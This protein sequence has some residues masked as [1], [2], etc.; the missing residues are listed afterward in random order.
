MERMATWG[1]ISFL[2]CLISLI[3]ITQLFAHPDGDLDVAVIRAF[4]N[5]QAS[6]DIAVPSAHQDQASADADNPTIDGNEYK[7]GEVLVKYTSTAVSAGEKFIFSQAVEA[8]KARGQVGMDYLIKR[9]TLNPNSPLARWRVVTLPKGV[10]VKEALDLFSSDP[11]VEV[12]EPN[13]I[14]QAK[15]IPNDALFE[16]LWGMK[17]IQAPLAWDTETGY[18]PIVVGVIDSGVD[19]THEDL[20]TNMWTNPGEVPNNGIDDDGNGYIDDVYGYDFANDDGDPW[21]DGYHGTHV[22]GTIG[23]VGNNMVGVAGVNW[24]IQIMAIKFLDGKTGRGT[25]LGAVQAIDY[26][27]S[28]GVK[29]TNNSWGCACNY[30]ALEDAISAAN[31]A[32]MLFIASA[33]NSGKDI[34]SSGAAVSPGGLQLPNIISVAATGSSGRLTYWSNY[35]REHVHLAAPGE[36]ILSTFPK[37]L[38]GQKASCKNT[39]YSGLS[40]TSMSA[41]HVT[42]AAAL[43]WS[44]Y[45]GLTAEEVKTW[46]LG[47]VDPVPALADKTITGGSLNVAKALANAASPV[48]FRVSLSPQ[49]QELQSGD[50]TTVDVGVKVSDS[51]SG[52]FTL[53]A[54]A[55]NELITVSLV[56]TE[57]NLLPG[58]RGSTS[59]AIA[60]AAELPKGYYP[61]EVV[62]TDELGNEDRRIVTY[63]VDGPSLSITYATDTPLIVAGDKAEFTLTLTSEQGFT[64]PISLSALSVTPTTAGLTSQI[65]DLPDGMT[66]TFIPQALDIA[67]GETQLVTMTVDTSTDTPA[68]KDYSILLA[69]E[70]QHVTWNPT[71][72]LGI[73]KL[74]SDLVN[75]E[76]WVDTSAPVNIGDS[77]ANKFS[78]EERNLGVEAASSHVSGI[79]LSTDEIIDTSDILI[80]TVNIP[81]IPGGGEIYHV[82]PNFHLPRDIEPGNYYIGSVVD[83]ESSVTESDESNNVSETV[84]SLLTVT[85]SID[86]EITEFVNSNAEQKRVAAGD[87]IRHNVTIK[88]NGSAPLKKTFYVKFYRSSDSYISKT[89]Q[90]IGQK[91]FSSSSLFRRNPITLDAGQSKTFEFSYTPGSHNTNDGENYYIGAFIDSSDN[92][93]EYDETN[94]TAATGPYETLHDIDLAPVDIQ[95]SRAQVNRSEAIELTATINNG[96]TTLANAVSVDFYLST[97]TTTTPEDIRLTTYT[98]SE[99]SAASSSTEKISVKTRAQLGKYYVG[100]I[101]N[102]NKSIKE[103]NHNNNVYLGEMIEIIEGDVELAVSSVSYQQDFVN[104]GQYIVVNYTMESRGT[105]GVITPSAGLY[106]S[107]DDMKDSSDIY[108]RRD[109]PRKAISPGDSIDRAFR[110]YIPTDIE[111]GNYYLIVD[112]MASLD[113]KRITSNKAGPVLGVGADFELSASELLANA[114]GYTVG[115]R[116]VLSYTLLNAGASTVPA[117]ETSI[118]LSKDSAHSSDDMHVATS[119]IQNLAGNS[120]MT[121]SDFTFSIPYSIAAGD[122]HL[123]A[124]VDHD[125]R[126]P[127]LDE[128]NNVVVGAMVSIQNDVDLEVTSLIPSVESAVAGDSVKITST[129]QNNGTAPMPPDYSVGIYLRPSTGRYSHHLGSWKP[130]ASLAQGESETKE[131]TV[132]M[133][134]NTRYAMSRY[135]LIA[136][137]DAG[138]VVNEADE[139]N[140]TKRATFKLTEDRDLI[141][142]KVRA[143]K[144]IIMPGENFKVDTTIVSNGPTPVYSSQY[145]YANYNV[146]LYLSTD[147]PVSG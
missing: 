19:Y 40:G 89:D 11:S 102:R 29:L 63:K 99:I 106:L 16:S 58:E 17:T 80:A 50:S 70:G 83:I 54:V 4:D 143:D 81:A 30:V 42:G 24:D 139:V 137:A 94:N 5:P 74:G 84:P 140:N 116:A 56:E 85:N 131:L 53:N 65:T 26:A 12:A 46:L 122:Y 96:G 93:A 92:L 77:M 119:S 34:T 10:S 27:T 141:V 57:L 55:P 15:A 67:A 32:G 33:G 35:G 115:D 135:S 114:S 62:A 75:V 144:N 147:P 100:M 104:P 113:S 112:A 124:K 48:G 128:T 1:R 37:A 142:T 43:L 103:T 108:L 117:V 121:V 52:K 86:L 78:I 105:V 2:S 31:D 41:P 71:I 127:E 69:A 8:L 14:S 101:V 6:G 39:A 73:W 82:H 111:L 118:Y 133:P 87:L 130:S 138:K 95:L 120:N 145:Y 68:G 66:V 61:I 44:A 20:A 13:A 47:G 64:G 76:L 98:F 126:I 129:I 36:G 88:N 3:S 9:K 110:A 123:I 28:M 134:T 18:R 59:M 91:I 109:Y 132:T 51:H 107:N 60:T 22:A 79:Y 21:D 23:A 7:P 90:F 25:L 45:P 125:R 49:F 38:C 97:D 72:P 146:G 136:T